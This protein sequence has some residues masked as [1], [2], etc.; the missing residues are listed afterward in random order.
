[1]KILRKVFLSCAKAS[2]LTEIKNA[3]EIS[4]IHNL[5]LHMHKQ[6]C[7]ICI[8]YEKQSKI[9]N[10]WIENYMSHHLIC[11]GYDVD[12]LKSKIILSIKKEAEN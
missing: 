6:M 7:N 4:V 3:G 12:K 8:T 5:Q 9:V 10:Q 1:M 11:E 2:E